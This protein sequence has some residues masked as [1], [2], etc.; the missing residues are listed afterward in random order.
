MTTEPD[1]IAAVIDK[2]AAEVLKGMSVKEA[3]ERAFTAIA[4]DAAARDAFIRLAIGDLMG[5]RLGYRA[6]QRA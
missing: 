5:E 3:S 1:R 2:A 4:A 6:R